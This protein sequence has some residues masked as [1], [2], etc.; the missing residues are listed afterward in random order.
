[1]TTATLSAKHLLADPMVLGRARAKA[2]S[3]ARDMRL[4]ADHVDDLTQDFLLVLCRKAPRFDAARSPFSAYV[5]LVL[6]QAAQD[7]FH[8]YAREREI[9]SATYSFEIGSAGDSDDPMTLGETLDSDAALRAMGRVGLGATEAADLRHDVAMVVASLPP[10]LRDVANDLM[11]DPQKLA[12]RRGIARSTA[13]RAIR[14]LRHAFAEAG[15]DTVFT[16]P[17]NISENT[18]VLVKKEASAPTLAERA[19][20]SG[21]GSHGTTTPARETPWPIAPCAASE[22]GP[23]A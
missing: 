19:E 23:P 8:K 2:R 11:E 15:L 9:A 22:P 14:A 18:P 21:P 3:L 4:A 12:Q 5:A 17:R 16:A 1:M 7:A 6:R 10:A 13:R 20:A